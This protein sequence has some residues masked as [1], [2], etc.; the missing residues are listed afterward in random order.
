MHIQARDAVSTPLLDASAREALFARFLAASAA[1][2]GFDLALLRGT[3]VAP[4]YF[5]LVLASREAHPEQGVAAL[6]AMCDGVL[7]RSG[8]ARP[9][10][11]V[12][13]FLRDHATA[14]DLAH[15]V[16]KLWYLGTWFDPLTAEEYA[17]SEAPSI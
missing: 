12:A 4:S 17:V 7:E 1:L 13:A 15:A 9:Q 3:G 14:S 11:D 16:I 8:A 6:R 10:A 2:T 5:E